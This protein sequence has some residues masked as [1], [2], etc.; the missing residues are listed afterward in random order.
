MGDTMPRAG[1]RLTKGE[2]I[3]RR[4]V[5]DE[6]FQGGSR[7]FSAFPVRAVCRLAATAGPGCAP[8]QILVSV[9]KRRLRH[10]VDRNRVKRQLR[11]AYRK[12]KPGRGDVPEG[13]RLLVAFV[14]TDDRTWPSAEVEQR[15]AKL[16]RRIRE[17]LCAR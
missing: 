15:V 13:Q 12:H 14:W 3:C 1:Q 7:S 2:R 16:L 4:T 8:C 9:P 17:K 10:A 11:E 6:L 5:V